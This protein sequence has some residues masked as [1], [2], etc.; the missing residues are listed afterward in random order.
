MSVFFIDCGL[1]L[2]CVFI[3]Y[4]PTNGKRILVLLP[5]LIILILYFTMLVYIEIG[6]QTLCNSLTALKNCDRNDKI[7]LIRNL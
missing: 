7:S 4:G 3:T 6:N 5:E 1:T 2:T